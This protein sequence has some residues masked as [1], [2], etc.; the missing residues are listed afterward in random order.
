MERMITFCLIFFC[1]SM[2]LSAAAPTGLRYRELVKTVT[3]L[4]QSVKVKEVEPLPISEDTVSK[5]LSSPINCFQKASLHLQPAN[6]Q[7][8]HNFQYMIKKLQR[9]IN[10]DTTTDMNCSPCYSYAKEAPTK[11]LNSFISLLQEQIKA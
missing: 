2:L 6:K 9:P 7:S 1:S 8:Q 5:C 4:K 10:N 11:F 3:L